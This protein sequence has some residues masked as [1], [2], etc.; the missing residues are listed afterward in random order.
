MGNAF[1]ELVVWCKK[2][3]MNRKNR[4]WKKWRRLGDARGSKLLKLWTPSLKGK[5]GLPSNAD[6]VIMTM[7]LI[8]GCSWKKTTGRLKNSKYFGNI[9]RF[10]DYHGPKSAAVWGAMAPSWGAATPS[11]TIIMPPSKPT[12][13]K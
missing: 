6:S 12:W 3:F 1:W 2:T 5:R 4:S 10:M 8:R 7:F 13:I 9:F 11:K